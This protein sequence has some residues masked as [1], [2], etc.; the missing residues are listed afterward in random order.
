[1]TWEQNG[2]S[3]DF[4]AAADLSSG[5]PVIVGNLIGVVVRDVESGD[6]GAMTLVGVHA[7][8]REA[9]TAFSAGDL[10]FWDA[11]G[12]PEGGTAGS[13]AVV[14]TDGGGVNRYLGKVTEDVADAAA[15]Q[16]VLVRLEQIR[17]DA[18]QEGVAGEIGD[19]LVI[20]AT[21]ADA[22][23]DVEVY[24]AAAPIAF[25]IIDVLVENQAANGANANTVQ[26]CA[27]AAGASPISDAI[28]LNGVADTDLVRAGEI[29]DA[30]ASIAVGDSLY[31]NVAKA[32]GTMGG[33]V[34]I[35]AI[36]G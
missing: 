33:I 2:N 10:A 31:V 27:A 5:D 12:D 17:P 13:G 21:F 36:R 6:E 1:M 3:I 8:P 34:R 29:D 20:S 28:S 25:R 16:Q 32:G 7:L 24:D 35:I 4:T 11:D 30:E 19:L 9:D 23:G 22:A 18:S 14:D 15:N 26:V